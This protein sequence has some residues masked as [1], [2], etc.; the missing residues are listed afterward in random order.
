MP[1]LAPEDYS[2]LLDRQQRAASESAAQAGRPFD[3]RSQALANL[4]GKFEDPHQALSYLSEVADPLKQRREELNAITAGGNTLSQSEKD[5]L[6]RI[7]SQLSGTA[8]IG[9]DVVNEIT[10]AKAQRLEEHRAQGT[11]SLDGLRGTVE[12]LRVASESADREL[13]NARR[14]YRTAPDNAEKLRPFED[15]VRMSE[16]RYKEAEGVYND[17]DTEAAKKQA[18]EQ[19]KTDKEQAESRRRQYRGMSLDNLTG[20]VG[21]L[22]DERNRKQKELDDAVTGGASDEDKGRLQKELAA[23][24]ARF[25]E[26]NDVLSRK[27]ATTAGEIDA[28]LAKQAE[29]L[30][31]E[32][33]S[34]AD[35]TTRIGARET[36]IQTIRQDIE[37]LRNEVNDPALPD[38]ERREKSD[39]LYE[40]TKRLRAEED[41]LKLDRQ[42]VKKLDDEAEAEKNKFRDM[43]PAERAEELKRLSQ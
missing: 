12:S 10:Q 33:S 35:L 32:R 28:D 4:V 22:K 25:N 41:T 30:T 31:R 18:R 34:I 15:A 8:S 13:K 39:R 42:Q 29:A 38:N 9:G 36:G 37:N 24:D 27:Q 40:L 21:D 43:S 23:L 14:I 7:N 26:A 17:M 6:E 2:H 3:E 1:N 19:A 11:Q 5:E 16:A 20:E